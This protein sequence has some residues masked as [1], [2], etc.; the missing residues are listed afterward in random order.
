MLFD[1]ATLMALP[2]TVTGAVTGSTTWL[3]PP[4]DCLPLVVFPPAEPV[5]PAAGWMVPEDC[6]PE[7]VLFE[8]STLMALPDAVMGAVTGAT[9]WLP[10]SMDC[11]PLVVLPPAE[12]AAGWDPV[13]A[14]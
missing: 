2:V 9:T 5:E 10:P 7:T 13:V 8:P 3:P 6:P 11:L 1:P 14:G 4:M 12:P